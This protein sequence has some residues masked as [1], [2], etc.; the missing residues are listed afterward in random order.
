MYKSA[1]TQAKFRKN[2]NKGT[3]SGALDASITLKKAK[4]RRIDVKL[5]K[6]FIYGCKGL[7]DKRH[8]HFI[9]I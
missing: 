1:P 7:F 2:G 3:A 4:W 6:V 9:L 5:Q 8:S